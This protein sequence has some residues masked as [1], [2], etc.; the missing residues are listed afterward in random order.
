MVGKTKREY[1]ELGFY[2][3]YKEGKSQD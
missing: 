1:I 2:T 3:G